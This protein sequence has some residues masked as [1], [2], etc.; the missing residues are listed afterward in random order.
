[1]NLHHLSILIII[2]YFLLPIMLVYSLYRG[3]DIPFH[4]M[5]LA[6]GTI[7][8]FAGTAYAID[9]WQLWFGNSLIA[10]FL[11]AVTFLIG[12]SIG[13]MVLALLPF[14]LSMPS[15]AQLEAANQA[16]EIEIV[17]RQR[18]Q[19][20]LED[21]TTNLEQQVESRTGDL[22][23]AIARLQ[24]EIHEREVAQKYLRRSKDQL[25]KEHQK[26]QQALHNLQHTQAQL[27]QA[28]K[29]SSLGQL[30]AGIAHEINN[31][32]NFIAG[33]IRHAESYVQDLIQLVHLYQETYPQPLQPIQ[34]WVETM[35]LDYVQLDLPKVLSSMRSGTDRI[36]EVVQSMRNFS[37]LDEAQMKQVDLHEGINST[38]LILHHR[39]KASGNEAE[40]QTVKQYDSLP[41]VECNS[42]LLNQVFMNILSNGIDALRESKPIQPTITISTCSTDRQVILRITDNGSGM[43]ETT[44]TK[45]FDPF[46]TTK[47]VGKGTGLGLYISHQIVV[48]KHGGTLRCLS[49]PGTGTTFEIVLPIQRSGVMTLPAQ[50]E[51]S[52]NDP[53]ATPPPAGKPIPKLIE[54]NLFQEK[55]LQGDLALLK[56]GLI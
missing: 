33:N 43:A 1:M 26:L 19:Q 29:M 20:S 3:R 18:A 30:V 15:P 44:Q 14:A 23:E 7:L 34:D 47:P 38:L 17:E 53:G 25:K 54:P 13:I 2:A 52:Q 51:S 22:S 42:G 12:I 56:S 27:I 40:I 11:T 46:F 31:P 10:V 32:I 41:L 6:F 50:P 37:R 5:F 24:R 55:N 49:A 36:V 35:E 39:L 21:L 16:L 8:S 28:E 45:L 9:H 4:W 48:E